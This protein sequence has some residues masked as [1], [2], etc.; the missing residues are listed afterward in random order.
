MQALGRGGRLVLY[1]SLSGQPL[2]FEPRALMVGHKS[3][4]GYWLSEWARGQGVL[5]MLSVFRQIGALLREGVVAT[6]VGATFALEQVQEAVRQ[7][8]RPGR[9]GKVILRIGSG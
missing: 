4:E 5:R 3:V 8:E 9:Q 7:A 2:G 6:E 1:S